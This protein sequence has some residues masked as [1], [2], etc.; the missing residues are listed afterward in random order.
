LR[1]AAHQSRPVLELWVVLLIAGLGLLYWW[2]CDPALGEPLLETFRTQG[3]RYLVAEPAL[4]GNPELSVPHDLVRLYPAH[5]YRL[6]HTP[7]GHL[8]LYRFIP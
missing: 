6:H 3:V 5:F 7:H 2:I 1:G 4:A 8:K